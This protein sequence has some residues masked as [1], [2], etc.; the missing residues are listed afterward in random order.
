[1]KYF[2]IEPEV[3]GGLGKNTVMNTERRRHCEDPR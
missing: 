2:Y 3:A 1:M